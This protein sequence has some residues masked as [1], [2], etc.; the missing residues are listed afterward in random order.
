MCGIVCAFDLKESA[1]DLRPQLLEM[2][3]K[4]RHRGPDWSGIYSDEKAILAHERLAIVD[5]ASGKQPLLSSDGKLVLAANGEIYN[6]R[7][8]RKRFEGSYEFKTESDC[9]VI[10]ALYKEKGVDF[11]DEMNG[12]FGFAI[13]DVEKD[14]YFVARDH[15]GIIPLY[16]GWDQNGT[17]YVASELKALE[18]V[19]TKIELFPPGHYLH[20][21]DGQFKRWYT[22]D[23]TE[24][25][26]VKDNQTSIDKIKEAL[27][28]AVHRQLMSDVPY[29]VLLSG[30][31]DS[32]VTSAIAKRYAEKRIESD[33][34]TEA[35]WPRL[36]SFSVGLEGSPDL[37][38]AQKV[39]DHIGTVHHEI[40]FT[41]Q[42]GLDAIKDVIYN[43][44]TYDITTIRASTP[45]Y[46]MAR[47]IKSMGIKMVLSGEGADELFGGYLYFHKAPNAQEFHEETVRKLSKLHM[48]D[49]L[50]ANKSLAAWGIEGRV[51]FLDKEFMDV[52][53]SINP[54][55]KMINGERMEKWV[56]RKAFESYLPES[57]AW[58]QKEQF[59]D[60]VGYSWIDTLKE[61]VNAEVSDEQLANAKFRF[62]IQTP[63]SKEEFYYRSIFHDHF[64]SDAAALCVP[65]EASV[66]CSTQI[67]L[68]WDEAFKNMNDPSGRAVAKVHTQAYE[69]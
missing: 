64:P 49:C 43:L 52:A 54:Q 9:E 29:G 67:A 24:Y 4:V 55:D 17:F 53:M 16:I 48:Y 5:P 61:M 59:S 60:G 62:P 40:K 25:D 32:S 8:L 47:V 1:E 14:E 56:V 69:S 33:D 39:A 65:Q 28:A 41:I 26:A 20:S 10:L 6:H 13:Y 45:M 27:E 35:W 58:R 68:E 23:W 50:R 44:E 19:C 18:G 30:G 36:H 51:P 38:A 31:L 11:I 34:S 37:A 66:A 22:R 7:E 15:M 46:L 2:S 12:I 63:T 57:V 42:E 21:S 3:K